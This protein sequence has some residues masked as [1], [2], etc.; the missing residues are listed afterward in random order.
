MCV[1]VSV[2]WGGGMKV[3]NDRVNKAHG[4]LTSSEIKPR[5]ESDRSIIYKYG[6]EGR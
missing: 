1:C 6:V 3:E 2:L 4:Y 5:F